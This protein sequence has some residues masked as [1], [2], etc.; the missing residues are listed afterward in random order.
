MPGT[1]ESLDKPNARPSPHARSLIPWLA[2]T[3]NLPSVQNPSL[4]ASSG[5]CPTPT[6]PSSMGPPGCAPHPP[7]PQ[8]STTQVPRA[9][10]TRWF[11]GSLGLNPTEEARLV[12]RVVMLRRVHFSPARPREWGHQ[13]SPSPTGGAPASR[14]R[15]S[16]RVERLFQFPKKNTGNFPSKH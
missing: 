13:S 5:S 7:S 8:T 12:T 11:C 16:H 14:H 9:T 6:K 15:E 3:W 2:C 10:R 1:Q 4:C